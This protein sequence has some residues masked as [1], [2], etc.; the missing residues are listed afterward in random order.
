MAKPFPIKHPKDNA[1]KEVLDEIAIEYGIDRKLVEDFS[2]K[3]L[4]YLNIKIRTRIDFSMP[5][6]GTFHFSKKHDVFYGEGWLN[7][8]KKKW[9]RAFNRK[10]EKRYKK[11]K[12]NNA[13]I[14]MKR[15]EVKI[16]NKLF[17][18]KVANELDYVL[19]LY[20]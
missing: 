6:W 11:R 14:R 5:A 2:N 12:K 8:K 4:L 3:F 9:I 7:G 18:R 10:D 1:Y 16:V 19:S 15:K 13:I 20:H 17:L